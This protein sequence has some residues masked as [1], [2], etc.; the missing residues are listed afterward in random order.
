M[1][2]MASKDKN[3]SPMRRPTSYPNSFSMMHFLYLFGGV[4]LIGI[5]FDARTVASPGLSIVTEPSPAFLTVEIRNA[6][7]TSL[8]SQSDPQKV[9]V[10][11]RA[12]YQPGELIVVNAP[13]Q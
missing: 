13:P 7:G 4:S 9:A 11:Y 5:A 6:T 8:A 1:R 12:V 3:R 2:M 10:S